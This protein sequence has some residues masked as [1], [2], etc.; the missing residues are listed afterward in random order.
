MPTQNEIRANITNTI[1]EA[2]KSGK[3]P[4]W[5]RPW[6]SSERNAGRPCNISG[7]KYSGI[8]PLLLE[9]ASMRYSFQSKWW[10]TWNQWKQLGGQV[11]R[12]PDN[13]PPGEWGTTIIFWSKIKKTEEDER[14]EEKERDIFFMKTYTVFNVEQVTGEGFEVFHVCHSPIKSPKPC[15]TYEKADKVIEATGAEIRYGGNRAFYNRRDD[16]IQVPLREQFTAG[17]FYETTFHELCHW[18]EAP[19]RLNWNRADEGYAMGELIAEMGSCFLATELGIPNAETLPNHASYLSSW[20]Q[21]M[22]NDT[23]FIF[24]AS[25]QASKAADYIL[26]FS[27]RETPEPEEVA[28]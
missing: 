13:V 20:L 7:R 17:E 19:S 3:L 21:A 9:I 16:Y 6:A 23:K 28:V 12:R 10:A 2:L 26:G 22:Q 25:S 14:G 18:S 4:P 5:R 8:N 1:V 15:D 27:R 11:M 24:Q